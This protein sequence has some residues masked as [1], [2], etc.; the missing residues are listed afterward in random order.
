MG[1]SGVSLG[2]LALFA[3]LLAACGG[4]AICIDEI[5]NFTLNR[6]GYDAEGE[7]FWVAGSQT[8]SGCYDD[9]SEARAVLAITATMD[10][11]AEHTTF[12]RPG[13]IHDVLWPAGMTPFYDGVFTSQCVSCQMDVL[14]GDGRYRLR[15]ETANTELADPMTLTLFDG[16]TEI[17]RFAFRMGDVVRIAP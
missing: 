10:G 8:V 2:V 3:G 1:K 4:S 17:A 12:Q 11:I 15:F 14:L 16:G 9:T 5:Q 13:T 7:K 6:V